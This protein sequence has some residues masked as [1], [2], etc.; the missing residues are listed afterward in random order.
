MQQK[1]SVTGKV[2]AQQS[3]DLGFNISGTVSSVE[4]Q[5]GQRVEQG[6]V[7]ARLDSSDISAQLAQAQA[8][9]QAAQAQLDSLQAGTRPEQI[10]VT[11]AQVQSDERSLAQANIAILNAIQS[12]Y[13]YSDD[14]V[15]NKVDQ[16]FNNARTTS[17]TLAFSTSNSQLETSLESQRVSIESMLSSW[18]SE[19]SG[20]TASQDLSSAETGAQQNLASVSSLLS[21]ANAALNSVIYTSTVTSAVVSGYITNIAT[22]RANVNNAQSALTTTITAQTAAASTLAKDQKTLALQQAGAT[23]DDINAQVAQV[24]AA[25]ANVDV[26]QAKVENTVLRAPF[27]GVVTRQDAKV[28]EAETPG[29]AL[30]SLASSGS[31]EIECYVAE[32]DIAKVALGNPA[33]VTLD[34]YGDSVPFTAKVLSIDPAETMLQGVSTY[35]VELFFTSSPQPVKSGMTANTDIVTATRANALS[36]PARAIYQQNGAQYVKV[37]RSDGTTE[38]RQVTTGIQGADGSVEITSG[39]QAGESVVTYTSQ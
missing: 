26:L 6:Q 31:F 39:L 9:L 4:A 2:K 12:A 3:V 16:F 13:S 11:Q 36:V 38:D 18:Q 22:A 20:L 1:V 32:A 33:N 25:Q 27:P 24:A 15:H 37:L 29:T 19:Q 10:A 8:Q 21:Q 28:G 7:L 34:A 5:V 23:P 35:K 30:V 14:A 17:P